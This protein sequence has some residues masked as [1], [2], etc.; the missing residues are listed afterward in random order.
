MNEKIF[1]APE[2]EVVRFPEQDIVTT[3]YQNPL[4]DDTPIDE[5]EW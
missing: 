3:S 1:S 2:A 4:G 5:F